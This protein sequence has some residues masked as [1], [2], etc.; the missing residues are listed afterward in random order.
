MIEISIWCEKF[1]VP[2]IFALFFERGFK[3]IEQNVDSHGFA[4]CSG[5]VRSTEMCGLALGWIRLALTM[6]V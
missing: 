3:P 2:E 6:L 1:M 5:I 4:I